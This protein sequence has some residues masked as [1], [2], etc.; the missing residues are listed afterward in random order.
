MVNQIAE[1]AVVIDQKQ[2]NDGNIYGF[3]QT[4]N[5]AQ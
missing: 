3:M 2:G 5:P 4:L 1:P